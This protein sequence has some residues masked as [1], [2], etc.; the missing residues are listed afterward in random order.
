ARLGSGQ[1]REAREAFNSF[2]KSA[3]S[4]PRSRSAQYRLGE[5]SYLLGDL[6][7]A[8]EALE[9]FTSA[10]GNHPS[11]EAAW[12]YL[13]DTCFGLED[14][15]KARVAYERSIAAFPEGRTSDR[16]RYGLARTLAGSGE[17]DKALSLLEELAKKGGTDWLDRCWLQIGLIRESD[18]RM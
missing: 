2:L 10:G 12:D 16:A 8:R 5:L 9:A 17:R 6:S 1:Y 14:L 13:G 15:P 18:G 4:D 11:L 3:A 7:V